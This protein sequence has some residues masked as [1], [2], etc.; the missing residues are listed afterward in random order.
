[1]QF[2]AGA[3]VLVV[4]DNPGKRYSVARLLRAAGFEVIEGGS[5]QEALDQA[6][7]GP[8]AIVLDVNLPDIDGYE[9]CRILRTR[10]ATARTPIIHLSATFVNPEDKVYGL[11]AGADGYLTHPVEPP[12]LVATV[13]AFIRARR[14]EEELRRSEAKFRTIFDKGLNGIALFD[15]NRVIR[16]ANPAMATILGVPGQSLAGRSWAEFYPPG[17]AAASQ[18]RF[19]L[20]KERGSWHGSAML[21]RPD[22][23]PVFVEGHVSLHAAPD[24]WIAVFA[25]AGDRIAAD[26]ERERLYASERAARTEAE[27]ANRLKDDFLA[28]VSHELRAPLQA[29]VGWSQLLRTRPDVD[30]ADYQMGIEAIHRNA[31][32]QSQLITD[33]LDVSRITSGKLR[34]ERRE[35]DLAQSI[36]HALD[37]VAQSAQARH[38]SVQTERGEGDLSIYGDPHRVQQV[39][40][41][42]LTNAIK[43]TEIG[44]SIRVGAHEKDDELV[45]S[46]IDDGQGISPEFLPHLFDAFRQEDAATTRRHEGLGLGLS[47]VR[48]IVEMHGGRVSAHSE[49]TGK[50]AT[51]CLFFPSLAAS[52]AAGE[53]A[54]GAGSAAAKPDE[55][56]EPSRLRGLRVLLVDDDADA[57]LVVRRLLDDFAVDTVEA[58][59]VAEAMQQVARH[60]PHLLVSDISMPGDDGYALVRRLREAGYDAESLPAI[61]LTAFAQPEDKARALANGFQ[62]HLGKPIDLEALLVAISAFAPR[63][64]G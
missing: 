3:T 43:F 55:P 57:R 31:R 41:Y 64:H 28:T 22:G 6:E 49:G 59:S 10:D 2:D 20:L 18:Q 7:T 35:L 50:G 39:V 19:D 4:D 5:G 34:L 37:S 13:R 45:V 12:V 54:Q 36:A 27:R 16:D 58:D 32:M 14:A 29:I 21:L 24:T 47:I 17:G 26:A 48:R 62:A 38:L 63:R 61:A 40:V 42:Q 51:F 60:A 52:K 44:G 25:D 23:T 56:L 33:L 30:L 46:V 1:M 15:S 11:E 9:V 8:D 53:D